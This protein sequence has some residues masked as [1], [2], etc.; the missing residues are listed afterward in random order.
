MEVY[1]VNDVFIAHKVKRFRRIGCDCIKVTLYI[2][3]NLSK[4]PF[5]HHCTYTPPT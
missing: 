3:K 2:R 1:K 4:L 5:D